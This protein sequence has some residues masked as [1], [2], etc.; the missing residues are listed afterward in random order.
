MIRLCLGEGRLTQQSCGGT[1]DALVWPPKYDLFGVRVSATDYAEACNVILQA[2]QLG[3]SAVVSFHAA[4]AVVTSSDDPLLR[5]AVNRFELVATDGQPVRWAMNLLHGTRL[6]DRVYGPELMLRLCRR[7]AVEGVPIYLYGGSPEV[8]KRL[9]ANLLAM[10]PELR[11]AGAES[12]P[13]RALTPEEDDALVQRIDASGARLVFI[14]LGC[15]KQDFFAHEHRGRIR[16]VQLCVG[17]AFDFHAGMKKTAPQ[18]MQ[19]SGLEWLF[20][21]GSE[22]RR[23]WRRYLV[24]NTLFVS[25]LARALLRRSGRRQAQA[26]E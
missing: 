24:T 11:I 21:L 6:R 1:N 19:R 5:Q 17:A 16:A 3:Q 14:G 23:L 18:W 2:A 22:P 13:Y 9:Q 20:R 10:F 8:S 12:P 4:H 26:S 15:P 25:K 7:A